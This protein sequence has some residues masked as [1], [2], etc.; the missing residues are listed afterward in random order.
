[1]ELY[2]TLGVLGDILRE[3]IPVPEIR[4]CELG[5]GFGEVISI[6]KTSPYITPTPECPYVSS[7]R[8]SEPDLCEINF[9]VV[10]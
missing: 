7:L 5:S 4:T 3:Q 9:I 6:F 2:R 1:M 8:S 10:R